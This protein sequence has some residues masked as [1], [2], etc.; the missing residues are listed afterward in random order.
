MYVYAP[1]YPSMSSGVST[2]YDYEYR[3]YKTTVGHRV[4]RVLPREGM[5]ATNVT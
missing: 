3:G 4:S 2:V 5:S 1:P